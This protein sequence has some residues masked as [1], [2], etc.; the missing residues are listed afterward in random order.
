MNTRD[1][2]RAALNGQPLDRLPR[3]E[4]AIWW[5][6]TI[7]RWHAEGLPIE[8]SAYS[9]YGVTAV[10]EYFG[11]DPAWQ[12]VPAYIAPSAETSSATPVA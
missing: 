6:E 11:L 5:Q 1:R 8:R 12:A 10:M 7:D 2:F 4:W 9:D 3:F